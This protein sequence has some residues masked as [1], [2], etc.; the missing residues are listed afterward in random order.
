MPILYKIF[1]FFLL[2]QGVKAVPG[3]SEACGALESIPLHA[4]ATLH[5]PANSGLLEKAI[6]LCKLQAPQCE[7]IR[8]TKIGAD[9]MAFETAI[10]YFT[11][12]SF[13]TQ[14]KIMKQLEPMQYE[15][16]LQWVNQ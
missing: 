12:L 8:E 14:S 11:N 15:I 1:L 2:Q 6:S 9:G 5:V 13:A 10:V 4:I 16:N 7:V 3:S